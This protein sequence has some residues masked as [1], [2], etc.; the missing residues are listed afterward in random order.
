MKIICHGDSLT[1]GSDLV[2]PCAWTALLGNRLNTP[3]VN[4]GISGDTTAGMLARFAV[5]VVPQKPGIVILMG[6]TNDLWYD[7]DVNLILANL[8]AMVNQAVFY[9]IAPIIG[10]PL[11]ICVEQVSRMDWT[12]PAK[13]YAY[14]SGRIRE[15][16]DRLAAE[17]AAWEVP[18]LNFYHLFL[19]D[20]AM[21][22]TAW[23]LAD[24]VHPGKPGH[25]AMAGHGAQV[26]AET[27]C[28][29]G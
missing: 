12:P 14:L 11:P 6:G 5:D 9:D 17:A 23:F 8:S 13:G 18:V 3:V 22:K 2:K 16:V 28:F 25:Q 19:D 21:E 29:Q 1:Q 7:L 20:Q 27:F 24:G 15:L 26:L 4:T 10:L